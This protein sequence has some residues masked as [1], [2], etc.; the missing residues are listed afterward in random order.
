MKLT[1]ERIQAIHAQAHCQSDDEGE[2]AELRELCRLALIG[3]AAESSMETVLGGDVGEV[4]HLLKAS[5]FVKTA[6]VLRAIK[7]AQRILGDKR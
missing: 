5:K 2:V 3:E 7:A 4:I 6:A 1:K